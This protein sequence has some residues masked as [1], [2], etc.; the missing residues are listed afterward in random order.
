MGSRPWENWDAPGVI[1]WLDADWSVLGVDPVLSSLVDMV[2]IHHGSGPILDVGCGTGRIHHALWMRTVLRPHEYVGVDITPAM[3]E[4]ARARYAGVD[5]RVGDIHDLPFPDG[6]FGS[7]VCVDV[8][9]HLP[10]VDEPIAELV[11]VA[12][13]HVFLLLWLPKTREPATSSELVRIEIPDRGVKAD[14]YENTWPDE[15][16]IAACEA[17]GGEILDFQ[18]I[19]DE[20]HDFGLLR[21]GAR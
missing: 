5:F 14:F 3:V 1:D 21:V 20:R 19:D 18:V 9:Q 7:V 4:R 10:A 17:A 13:E 15:D 8:L 2:E 11:R 16:L 6:A 12:R